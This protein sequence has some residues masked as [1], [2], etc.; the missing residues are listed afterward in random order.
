[1]ATDTKQKIPAGY[2][3]TEVGVIPNDWELVSFGNAFDFK[4]TAAYPREQLR[5]N[6]PVGYIHYGDIHTKWNHIVDIDTANLPAINKDQ[7][8]PYDFVQDGDLVVV[9]ASE[10]YSGVAKSVE[11]KNVKDRRIISG[12]HTFLL[13]SKPGFFENGFKGY[14]NSGKLVK[15]GLDRYATGM[16]VFG[17]SRTNLKLVMIPRPKP[18]EQTAIADAL[19]D[20]DALIEKLEKLIEKKKQIKQGA[21]QELLG[22]DNG[23]LKMD[24]GLA[25]KRRLPGFS[26]EWEVRRIGD[27][28]RVTRGQVLAMTKLQSSKMGEYK[29]PVYSSQ[30]HRDGLAGFYND[31]LFEDCITWTTDGANAGEVKYRSGKFYCTNVCGVL[32]SKAGYAN[33]CIAAI[34]NSISRKYV[35][36]VGNPKLMNNT[37][38]D[39]VIRIPKAIDEQNAIAEAFLDMKKEITKQEAILAKYRQMKI[40]MMQQLLTGKIRLIDKG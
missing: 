5:D 26:G 20:A 19:S 31:Y 10:D 24:N 23:Q 28:F 22:I 12:L 29:Y 14:I 35:S 4:R 18:D 6:G 3:Q 13:R 32:E 1:M 25:P 37:V 39:I 2:K 16:K 36:Y 40:G 9:D 27:I 33:P 30:T 17:V 15:D 34:F 7:A 8:K 21:M 11:I 38:A